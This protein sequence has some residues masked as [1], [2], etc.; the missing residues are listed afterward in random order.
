MGPGCNPG[1]TGSWG[2]GH[3]PVHVLQGNVDLGRR[4]LVS[5]PEQAYL[6]RLCNC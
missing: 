3:G 2:T 1:G 4:V 6:S 5:A